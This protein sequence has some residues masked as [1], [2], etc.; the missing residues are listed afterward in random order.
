MTPT[1]FAQFASDMGATLSSAQSSI[2]IKFL[3]SHGGGLN[4]DDFCRW[5]TR[6]DC[7]KAFQR[8]EGRELDRCLQLARLY[9]ACD[10]DA[11]GVISKRE[12]ESSHRILLENSQHSDS[13]ECVFDKIDRKQVPIGCL[14]V[15]E[16]VCAWM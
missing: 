14:D 2:A 13:I 7:F 15:S 8:L 4:L 11:D 12:F 5:W 6:D 1:L 3:D 9:D 16:A 10:Q